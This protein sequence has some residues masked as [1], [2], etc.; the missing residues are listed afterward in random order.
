MTIEERNTKVFDLYMKQG[1]KCRCGHQFKETDRVE[2]AHKVPRGEVIRKVGKQAEWDTE[3]LE[4]VCTTKGSFGKECNSDALL[5]IGV[6]RDDL[7][8]RLKEKYN[9][10]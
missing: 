8:K 4:L 9:V 5:P 1:G 6:A 3:A 2:L 7:I 10:E